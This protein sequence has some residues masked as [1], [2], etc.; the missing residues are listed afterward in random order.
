M[1][2]RSLI[3]VGA[4]FVVFAVLAGAF[5]LLALGARHTF[6]ARSSYSGV[7]SLVVDSGDG[8]VHLTGAPAGSSVHVVA[9]VT[10][11]FGAPHRRALRS[12]AG[13]VR[14]TYSCPGGIPGCSVSYDVT[15]PAGVSVT[16][17]AGAGT[18]DATGINTSH[19]SLES[20]DG[21]VSAVLS[22]PATSLRASSGNGTVTLVVPDV[23]YAVHASSGTGNVSERS[24]KFAPHS[25][26]RIDASSGNGDVT[27]TAAR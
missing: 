24:L 6:A 23:S 10:E 26:H 17:S 2:R 13:A 20:G 14:L 4:V 15:V 11:S 3:F 1:L 5:N 27:I 7:R 25:A 18:V 12:A 8:D 9:H 16:V 22:E 21:D 19:V